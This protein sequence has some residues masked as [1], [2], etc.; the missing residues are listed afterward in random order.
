MQTNYDMKGYLSFLILWLLNKEP[1]SGMN[2]ALEIERRK[3]TKPSPGTIY[4]ALKELKKKCYIEEI[5][6]NSRGKLYQLT[7]L[8]EKALEKDCE[9]FCKI[10]YDL[11]ERIDIFCIKNEEDRL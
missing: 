8:G 4:P 2:L 3:G 6:C 5:N 11:R 7:T 1:K 10:F 9:A